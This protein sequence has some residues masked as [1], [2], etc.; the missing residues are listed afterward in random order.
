MVSQCKLTHYREFVLVCEKATASVCLRNTQQNAVILSNAKD[1]FFND[2]CEATLDCIEIWQ[3]VNAPIKKCHPEW[4]M[5]RILRQTQSK[6]LLL[7]PLQHLIC[8]GWERKNRSF[9]LLRMTTL[10]EVQNVAL[11]LYFDKA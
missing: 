8:A 4:S 2:P 5:A 9:A 7:S 1:L 10:L 6:D 3:A 11:S